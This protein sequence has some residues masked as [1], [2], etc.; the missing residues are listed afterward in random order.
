M[1]LLTVL[2]CK[3]PKSEIWT[4]TISLCYVSLPMTLPVELL[5]NAHDTSC[6]FCTLLLCSVS[7]TLYCPLLRTSQRQTKWSKQLCNCRSLLFSRSRGCK[8]IISSQLGRVLFF[9]FAIAEVI[10]AWIGVRVNMVFQISQKD[11]GDTWQWW[12]V[13][14]QLHCINWWLTSFV[15]TVL[16]GGWPAPPASY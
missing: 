10:D 16:S 5:H 4:E 12:T 14:D 7:L 2:H 13:V 11:S 1:S 8:Q 9:S 6:G 15:F 3:Q